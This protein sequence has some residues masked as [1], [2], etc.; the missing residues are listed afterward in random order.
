MTADTA[1]TYLP[2]RLGAHELVLLH[3]HRVA[4]VVLLASVGPAGHHLPRRA[5]DA[6]V[7]AMAAFLA[8]TDEADNRVERRS[9]PVAGRVA[10]RQPSVV[11]IRRRPPVLQTRARLRM[12]HHRPPAP[13]TRQHPGRVAA[14]RLGYG[15]DP[16]PAARRRIR[17][18]RSRRARSAQLARHPAR[19]AMDSA[20]LRVAGLVVCAVTAAGE[21]GVA[22][23]DRGVLV[24][25]PVAVSVSVAV[26]VR[27]DHDGL[28]E[29]AV[30]DRPGPAHGAQ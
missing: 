25:G 15:S 10:L 19:R 8:A 21:L 14:D 5:P 28:G 6:V 26:T 17:R 7:D 1:T 24:R 22:G 18:E 2:A 12:T 9:L 23:P 3:G 27:L 30:G 16:Q 4:A 20:G 11:P 29:G 13:G